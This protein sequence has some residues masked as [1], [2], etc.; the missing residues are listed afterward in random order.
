[1][2]VLKAFEAVPKE[3]LVLHNDRSP[4]NSSYTREF[5]SI[6]PYVEMVFRIFFAWQQQLIGKEN[7]DSHLPQLCCFHRIVCLKIKQT[8]IM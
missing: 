7:L 4:S 2:E 8:K 1:M 6:N 3:N 5:V